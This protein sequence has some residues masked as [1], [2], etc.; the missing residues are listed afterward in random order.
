VAGDD[1][2]AGGGLA[3]LDEA[4]IVET[5]MGGLQQRID[6]MLEYRLREAL[7]PV[8]ARATDAVLH[9]ARDELARTLHDVV[10]RAVSQELARR[11]VR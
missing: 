6:L 4:R 8:L 3:A 1:A 7:A 5:V 9:E 10:T 11:R 2:A